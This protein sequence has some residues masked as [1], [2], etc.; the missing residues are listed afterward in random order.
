MA[1]SLTGKVALITGGSRGIGEKTAVKLAAEGATVAV[2]YVSN[3]NKAEAVVER[4]TAQ[5]GKAIAVQGDI[6]NVEDIKRIFSTTLEAFGRI[7]ILINNAGAMV[8]K[9]IDQITEEDFDRL[10]AINVKGTYFAIKEAYRY[11]EEDGRIINLSTSVNGNMFP[12]YSLYAGTKGA[13]E[14]FTRQLAKEFGPKNITINTIAPG[15]IATELFFADKTE[16]QI[17]TFKNNNAFHRLGTPEDIGGAISLLLSREASWIT[18][19]TLRVNGG[20]I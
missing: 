15:P 6:A 20:F 18:G 16:E 3:K 4:I 11:L 1:L 17:E 7:D 10:F 2:N 5:G 14:Q 12:T 19:Q 8:T 13:V 9:P